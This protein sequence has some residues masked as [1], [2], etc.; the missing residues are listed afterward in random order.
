M[1][2][3]PAFLKDQEQLLAKRQL[4]QLAEQVK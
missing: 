4:Q 3:W 2:F 1:L